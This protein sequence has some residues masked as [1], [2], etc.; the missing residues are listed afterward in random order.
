MNSLSRKLAI[1]YGLL[2]IILLA[3]SAWSVHHL[4]RLGTSIDK[5]LVNNYKSILAA[6]NMKEA[7]EREDSS[8]MFFIAGHPDKARTQLNSSSE[9]FNHEFQIAANNITEPGEAEIV[10]DINAKYSAY[11]FRLE[12][13]LFSQQSISGASQTD[14]YFGRLEPDFVALKNRLDDLLHLNQQAMVNANDRAIAETHFAERSTAALA[15]VALVFA[16]IFAWRFTTYIVKPISKLTESARRIGEGDLNQEIDVRSTDEIGR[17][18]SEFNRMTANLRELRQSDYGKMLMERKKSDAVI[19]SIYEPVIVTDAHGRTIKLNRAAEQLFNS[20]RNGNGKTGEQ[21]EI[22][23]TG[24]AAGDRILRAVKDAVALQRPVAGEDEAALVPIKIGGA[25]MSYRLRTT[26][27]RDADG[28]LIGAVTLLEDVTSIREVDRLKTEFIS[29][30]SS[31]LRRPLDS[32]LL[33]LHAFIQKNDD[34]SVGRA[35]G[36]DL[37][38]TRRR[39]SA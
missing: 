5:I 30:A 8:A 37:W 36:S 21:S 17:L 16:F 1:S 6:E 12:S 39:K 22:S 7:L 18:A 20:S 11:H 32:L 31:K 29:V 13:L 9:R 25:E 26:P 34:E 14:L 35:K 2:I 24:F 33:G 4:A 15:I 10:A 27:I 38:R 3:V 19:D 28:R 23:L